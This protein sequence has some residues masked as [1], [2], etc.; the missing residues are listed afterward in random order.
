MYTCSLGQTLLKTN[1]LIRLRIEVRP[2]ALGP[3]LATPTP[4]HRALLARLPISML[5]YLV[6]VDDVTMET[7]YYYSAVGLK[8]PIH[9]SKIRVWGNLSLLT[10]TLI[11]SA[12]RA[13]VS[14]VLNRTKHHKNY[15][16]NGSL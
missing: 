7:Y 14:N 10:L 6:P 16:F 13:I 4:I 11:F 12:W 1:C 2:T 15:T 8:T 9:A 3:Q 5:R